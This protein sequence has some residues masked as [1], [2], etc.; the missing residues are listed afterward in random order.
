MANKRNRD[1][2]PGTRVAKK[3]RTENPNGDVDVTANEVRMDSPE[4]VSDRS[5][6]NTPQPST[7][8]DTSDAVKLASTAK[9][10]SESVWKGTPVPIQVPTKAAVPPAPKTSK[11]KKLRGTLSDSMHAPGPSEPRV[12]APLT[13][14][15]AVRP[16]Q[17][18]GLADRLAA[19]RQMKKKEEKEV[20][21]TSSPWM[22]GPRPGTIWPAQSPLLDP[23]GPHRTIKDSKLHSLTESPNVLWVATY[24]E[25]KDPSKGP[26]RLDATRA[27]LEKKL[28]S[29]APAITE[30]AT[31]YNWWSLVQLPDAQSVA[32]LLDQRVVIHRGEKIAIFFYPVQQIPHPMQIAYVH[33]GREASKEIATILT[34][35]P[36]EFAGTV[37][38]GISTFF[39]IPES[40]VEEIPDWNATQPKKIAFRICLTDPQQWEK[41]RE[42]DEEELD[43]LI[44]WMDVWT[45]RKS[46]VRVCGSPVID[47]H[48]AHPCCWCH[49][50][51]HQGPK[52]PWAL[53][54]YITEGETLSAGKYK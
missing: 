6:S 31:A 27:F 39:G 44:T 25:N 40:R 45:T 21:V 30:L 9:Q 8:M 43:V 29:E 46:M 16:V 33:M 18:T 36:T 53:P 15:P 35:K 48:M 32:L 50:S 19:R 24:G 41:E 54:G 23:A 17:A 13:E 47:L 3:Q 22:F 38:R 37:R 51:D 11:P 52:C 10:P 28:G 4:P 7:P 12:T 49:A 14:L 34:E 5:G 20:E 1:P 26:L 42:L 2:P